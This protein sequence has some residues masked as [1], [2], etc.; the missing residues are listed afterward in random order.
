MATFKIELEHN[1]ITIT[2]KKIVAKDSSE[3][4][5][6]AC[7]WLGDKEYT[8]RD[9]FNATISKMNTGGKFQYYCTVY[10]LKNEYRVITKT[11]EFLV[12]PASGRIILTIKSFKK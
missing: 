6:H 4:I 1:F 3:A 5:S 7:L 8:A 10:R 9:M 2:E 11:A 12:D